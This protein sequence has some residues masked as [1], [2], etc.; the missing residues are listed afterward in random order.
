MTAGTISPVRRKLNRCYI[1]GRFV[2]EQFTGYD[3]D[4]LSNRGR[5]FCDRCVMR[6]ER[7]EQK[8]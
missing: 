1:C 8:K 6:L 5:L 4:R 7:K 3:R 2:G